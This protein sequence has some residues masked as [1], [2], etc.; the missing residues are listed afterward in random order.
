MHRVS[1]P[2]RMNAE[3][4]P[5]LQR[6]LQKVHSRDTADGYTREY[7]LM[8]SPVHPNHSMVMVS[9]ETGEILAHV[10]SLKRILRIGSARLPVALIGSVATDPAARGAGL[11]SQLLQAVHTTLAAEDIWMTLL[12]SDP[13]SLYENAGYHPAG[14]ARLFRISTLPAPPSDLSGT[15]LSL[16]PADLAA[17]PP[18]LPPVGRGLERSIEDHQL[19]LQIPGIHS[20][21]LMRDK[22][23]CSVIHVGKGSDF[24]GIVHEWVGHVEDV[25]TLMAFAFSQHQRRLGILLPEDDSPLVDRAI[26]AGWPSIL[27]PQATLKLLN[28][29]ACLSVLRSELDAFSWSRLFGIMNGWEGRERERRILALLFGGHH[30]QDLFHPLFPLHLWGLDS[31]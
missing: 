27:L 14:K 20:Y 18:L 2:R 17:H 8:L 31:M 16:S 21:G 15:C 13:R 3:E 28:V 19:L 23:L 12:W 5:S 29:A 30:E 9:E 1:P 22:R 10:G 4:W 26:D 24:E 11:A 25:W 6:L 7:P